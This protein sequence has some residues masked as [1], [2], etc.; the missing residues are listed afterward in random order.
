MKGQCPFF[1]AHSFRYFATLWLCCFLFF[2][3]VVNRSQIYQEEKHNGQKSSFRADNQPAPFFESILAL[4]ARNLLVTALSS[5]NE[6]VVALGDPFSDIIVSFLLPQEQV[7][8]S[9]G[10]GADDKYFVREWLNHNNCVAY[11]AGLAGSV[12][13]EEAVAAETQCT[14]HA[15][16]CTLASA[17]PD[18]GFMTFH[19]W[20]IGRE[21]NFEDNLY[22]QKAENKSFVFKSLGD[23][24]HLLG[25]PNIDLLKMD[26]EGFEWDLL[27][28]SLL[29]GPD[30]D[31]P[32]QLLF[33]LHAEGAKEEAVPPSIVTGRSKAA[34]DLLF[35]NLFDRGYR[36]INKEINEGDHRCAEFALIHVDKKQ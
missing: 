5:I 10:H 31:L 34:V 11:A 25:H 32:R 13:F 35:L 27:E 23:I 16:D 36:V 17:Q 3:F 30:A 26:I 19:R 22:S 15:F 4:T 28:S 6:D 7:H 20:C 21:R 18:W 24:K 1:I 14:V 33:E 2:D 29:D 12:R 8:K 9:D